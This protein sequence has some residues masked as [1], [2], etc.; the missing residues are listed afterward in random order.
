VPP[1][2][3]GSGI[4]PD[5]ARSTAKFARSPEPDKLKSEKPVA[6]SVPYCRP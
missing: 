2:C 3:V 6:S 1:N 5:V 4:E